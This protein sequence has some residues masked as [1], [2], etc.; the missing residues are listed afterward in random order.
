MEHVTSQWTSH[1]NIVVSQ[2]AYS[3]AIV[4]SQ[5]CLIFYEELSGC[6]IVRGNHQHPNSQ[7]CHEVASYSIDI[8]SNFTQ[9]LCQNMENS[10]L[11]FTPFHPKAR[12]LHFIPDFQPT[13][14]S[15]FCSKPPSIF[16]SIMEM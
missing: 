15:I 7:H 1:H 5:K 16:H 2:M 13:K 6:I 3:L 12:S 11:T 10:G 8:F 14:K 9:F 4:M